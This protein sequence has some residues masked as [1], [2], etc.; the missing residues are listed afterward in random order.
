MKNYLITG[1]RR[2]GKSFLTSRLQK[3]HEVEP[4]GFKTMAYFGE[5]GK[6]LGYLL[7]SLVAVDG[8]AN[9]QKISHGTDGVAE[10]FRGLGVACLQ[11]CLCH[12]S[13]WVVL[14]ELGR[15]EQYEVSFLKKV[16]E[17]LESQK[18]VVAVLK[19]EEIPYIEE[20]KK[21]QDCTVIDLDLVDRDL[22]YEEVCRELS[23]HLCMQ[24]GKYD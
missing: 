22:A 5:D 12:K 9:D 6:K 1:K 15:F 7:H 14:D 20:M 17:V 11:E 21:R 10:V 2:A 16:E 18:F 19:K 13:P 23:E 8:V 3:N 4:V 24:K